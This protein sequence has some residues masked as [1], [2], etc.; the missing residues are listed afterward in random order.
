MVERAQLFHICLHAVQGHDQRRA[1][2]KQPAR[3]AQTHQG[4]TALVIAGVAGFEHLHKLG[5]PA[6]DPLRQGPIV[7]LS[8]AE[9]VVSRANDHNFLI[10]LVYGPLIGNFDRASSVQAGDPLHIHN[11]GDVWHGGGSLD[12]AVEIAA[13]VPVQVRRLPGEAVGCHGNKAPFLVIE[14][15]VVE[16]DNLIYFI[17][18][19]VEAHDAPVLLECCKTHIAAVVAIAQDYP[20]GAPNLARHIVDAVHGTGGH[21]YGALEVQSGLHKG[22]QHPGGV[23][24]AE[25][26]ALQHQAPIHD[27]IGCIAAG[28]LV[29]SR[30]H[31][32]LHNVPPFP[33]FLTLYSQKPFV[34][35]PDLP[36]CPLLK[37][38]R[39][40]SI[41]TGLSRRKARYPKKN[42][43]G[44]SDSF[45][46]AFRVRT[47]EK[48]KQA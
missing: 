45:R 15:L 26:P 33:F 3:L 25:G 43:F 27:G 10:A 1:D 29:D 28:E 17:Q 18:G 19:K 32:V 47:C 22:V 23:N 41:I 4:L 14:P 48:Y 30:I 44:G 39:S 20:G 9:V 7:R 40:D 21:A 38:R 42:R 2:H 16:G 35:G 6:V 11:P 46:F 34:K 8:V 36:F 24:P 13:G 37:I 5:I 12:G 31:F